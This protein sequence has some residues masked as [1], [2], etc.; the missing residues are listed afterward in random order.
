MMVRM[1][2]L[3]NERKIEIERGVDKHCSILSP[4]EREL[5][6]SFMVENDDL[7]KSLSKT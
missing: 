5:F 3:T 7:M 4:K 2:E 1:M 6:K